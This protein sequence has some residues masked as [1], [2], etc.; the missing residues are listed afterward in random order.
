MIDHPFLVYAR[1]LPVTLLEVDSIRELPSGWDPV[2]RGPT[3][4]AIIV[5]N[6]G[7]STGIAWTSSLPWRGSSGSPES[8]GLCL[9]ALA[10]ELGHVFGTRGQGV[11]LASE[12]AALAWEIAEIRRL[13]MSCPISRA[14]ARKVAWV[15]KGEFSF[16]PTT[17]AWVQ[18]MAR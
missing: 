4:A 8:I 12:Y 5:V 9:E 2:G 17:D 3:D 14:M 15:V 13:D 1:T 16:G 6:S 18:E 7:L 11:I 10:H